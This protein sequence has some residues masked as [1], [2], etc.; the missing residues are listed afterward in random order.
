VAAIGAFNAAIDASSGT[1]SSAML[2][3]RFVIASASR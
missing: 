1:P 2:A 3:I